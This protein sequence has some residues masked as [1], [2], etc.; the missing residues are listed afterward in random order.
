[1]VKN[2]DLGGIASDVQF[3]K[4]G[5]RIIHDSG[6]LHIKNSDN[7]AYYNLKVGD[8]QASN[9]VI[10]KN[11]FDT[12]FNDTGVVAGT[13]SRPI[14]SVDAKGRI[15]SATSGTDGNAFIN[16]SGAPSSEIGT[17]GDMYYDYTNKSVYGPKNIG[18]WGSG[19]S[20]VGLQGT[21]GAGVVG[22]S[23]IPYTTEWNRP[24]RWKKLA[25][26][27]VTHSE[28]ITTDN[29]TYAT[30]AA[31]TLQVG[32]S[33]PIQQFANRT[34]IVEAVFENTIAST[35]GM[36]FGIGGQ[37]FGTLDTANAVLLVWRSN[38][39]L[40]ISNS[41]AS[42]IT[43]WVRTPTE[44]LTQ[45]A[46]VQNDV[47]KMIWKYGANP[48][49]ATLTL[50]KNN[51]PTGQTFTI[52][53]LTEGCVWV[54]GRLT[55]SGQ[56]IKINQLT[57]L[58]NDSKGIYYI[59]SLYSGVSNESETKPFSSF[60]NFQDYINAT[61]QRKFRLY[62]RGDHRGRTP[63][64]TSE[65]KEIE[66]FGEVGENVKIYGSTL[67]T[68]GW[69]ATAGATGVWERSGWLFDGV[70]NQ[71]NGGVIDPNRVDG[72]KP[73]TMYSRAAANTAPTSL[74]EG[75]TTIHTS[76]GNAQKIFIKTYGGVD[77]NTLSLELVNRTSC[78]SILDSGSG[79][80]NTKVVIQGIQF[81]YASSYN[82]NLTLCDFYLE[83][84]KTIGSLTTSC[85]G[86][87][88]A[89]GKASVCSGLMAYNDIWSTVQAGGSPVP[90]R[91]FI[92]LENCYGQYTI[93]GDGVSSHNTAHIVIQGGEFSDTEKDGVVLAGE[94]SGGIVEC[95]GVTCKRNK[96]SSFKNSGNPA[97]NTT[98][99]MKLV[100]CVSDGATYGINVNNTTNASQ[101]LLITE[102]YNT[103]ITNATSRKIFIGNANGSGRASEVVLRNY[104]TLLGGTGTDIINN[105][106]TVYNEH[107]RNISNL[108]YVASLNDFPPNVSG[109]ITLEDNKTYKI[110]G[111][112]DL[113][114]NRIVGGANNV[115]EGTSSE[116]SR[117]KSTGLIGSALLTS[118]KTI[119][120]KYVTIEADIAL[121]LNGIASSSE[122]IDWFGVNF[123]NCNTVGTISNYANVIFVAGSFLN[124]QG[125]TFDG[126]IGTVAFDQTLFDCKE[127]GTMLIFPATLTITRRIR[128]RTSAMIVLSGETGIN[129]STSM[130]IPVESFIM[131]SVN[132]SGGGTYV[133]GITY[134]D[135]KS[136]WF[137][138]KGINNSGSVAQYYMTGNATATSVSVVGTYYK[139]AGTTNSGSLIQRF[140]H[141]NNRLTY[142]GGI[143]KIFEV[144]AIASLT[145]GSGNTVK[146]SIYKNGSILPESESLATVSNNN[147]S[148]N[149]KCQTL[150]S[151]STNDYFEIYVA[152]NSAT[153]NIT[154]SDLNV[155][156]KPI[157]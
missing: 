10:T 131:D 146:V 111:T 4:N 38:G 86:L 148:E 69:T 80:N 68:S 123:T 39:A 109:V 105:N 115:I 59:D 66:I 143:T 67:V 14:I 45:T 141:T 12:N 17:D 74:V 157:E 108:V 77:P 156:V 150:V 84:V 140:N 7:S 70:L 90:F 78:L 76:G 132:F 49:T 5:P 152:N 56:S 58:D 106:A 126:T 35:T 129:A 60:A 21:S 65:F 50:F 139:V 20:L 34:I 6:S 72:T 55:A 62:V 127:S 2:F 48:S 130:S 101:G 16:G 47:L 46:W 29:L 3:G 155:I 28:T 92:I 134:L 133:T 41:A 25:G 71:G 63:S 102:T 85:F 64:F 30:T 42:T 73:F 61:G 154:V 91:P 23:F 52:T 98:Q 24:Q 118:T 137:R 136:D 124:S 99:Y 79:Y 37:T 53:G 88:D 11:Y 153:Q 13:Y 15:T 44:N 22:D 125:L 32:P 121:N 95:Y 81:L 107:L 151:L 75:Q 31:G 51:V 40:V 94:T 89:R 117:L 114:G 112:V 19:V 122:V 103:V 138:C 96:D 33:I 116:N 26:S 43:T 82:L 36:F 57:V 27:A 113:Q 142:T 147:R 110:I 135:N 8:P 9:D 97:T 87:L 149:I 54:G 144:N 104:N 128:I 83:N 18:S 119:I 145:S 1:M 93:V 100:N 120:L